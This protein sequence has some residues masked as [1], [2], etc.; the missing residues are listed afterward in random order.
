M[1]RGGGAVPLGVRASWKPAAEGP[2]A[3]PLLS[4]GEATVTHGPLETL[5]Q[6]RRR[7]QRAQVLHIRTNSTLHKFVIG[8]RSARSLPGLFL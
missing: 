8:Y 2:P 6:K 5:L 3:L 1:A 7:G 4:P